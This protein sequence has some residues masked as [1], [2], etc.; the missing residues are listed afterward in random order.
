VQVGDFGLSRFLGVQQ[1]TT[2]TC[3]TVSH[4]PPELISQGA[5]SKSVDA[6]SF[7]VLLWEVGGGG[8]GPGQRRTVLAVPQGCCMGGLE[9]AVPLRFLG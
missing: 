4:M 6:Y 9:L 8:G 1:L 7:G 2:S 5:L 3:G